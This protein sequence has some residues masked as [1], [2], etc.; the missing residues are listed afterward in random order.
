LLYLAGY[1]RHLYLYFFFIGVLMRCTPEHG[2]KPLIHKTVYEVADS[3]KKTIKPSGDTSYLEYIFR[4]YD[5]VNIQDLDSSIVVRLNYADTTNFMKK[6][7]YDGLKRAYFNCETAWKLAGAQYILNR[8]N[9]QYDLCILDASRPQHI[10]QLMW[11]SLKMHPDIK[12]NYLSPP[13]ETSLH[14]YGCAVDVTILDRTTGKLLEM[15]SEF[16]HFGRI[17]EPMFEK[18]FLKSG[19]LDTVAYMNR[20]LLR[21]VM[22][23][24]G[25]F[26]IASEWWHF[27]ICKRPEAIR[28]FTLIK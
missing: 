22:K 18:Q 28:N 20:Q 24:A 5:L 2:P 23:R 11:D 25:F 8:E 17:S 14:N 19:E 6:D 26:P 16:D 12:Y 10:Q 13:Y 7:I 9:P 15:G 21:N 1:L 3:V 4:R 27:S